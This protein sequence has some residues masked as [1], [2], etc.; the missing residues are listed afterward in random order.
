MTLSRDKFSMTLCFSG[1]KKIEPR[2][3]FFSETIFFASVAHLDEFVHIRSSVCAYKNPHC[4][5]KN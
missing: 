2:R 4:A 5:R 3:R 1:E